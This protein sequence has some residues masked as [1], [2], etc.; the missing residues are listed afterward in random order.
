MTSGYV[1]FWFSLTEN[2]KK[3][4]KGRP[5][6]YWRYVA[7]DERTVDKV[8]LTQSFIRAYY[9]ETYGRYKG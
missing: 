1:D 3:I 5:Q 8:A 6:W 7:L 4:G 2:K 9:E